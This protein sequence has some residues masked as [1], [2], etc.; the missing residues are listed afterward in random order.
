MT[1]TDPAVDAARRAWETYGWPPARFD[2]ADTATYSPKAVPIE[3]AREALAPIREVH[4]PFDRRTMPFRPAEDP[5]DVVCNHSERDQAIAA[6]Q[7]AEARATLHREERDE[8]RAAIDRV[9]E[10]LN[11]HPTCD[12][13]PDDDPITCGWKRAVADVTHALREADRG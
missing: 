2:T 7:R 12:V 1:G 6:H 9:R 8:A 3:A 10:A 4:K 5:H 11:R 13:H